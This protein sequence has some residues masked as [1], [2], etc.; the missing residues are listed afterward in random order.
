MSAQFGR[1]PLTSPPAPDF[2]TGPA[3]ARPLLQ[4]PH[5]VRLNGTLICSLAGAQFPSLSSV[6][7]RSPFVMAEYA[8]GDAFLFS[9]A[10]GHLLE[11]FDV[12]NGGPRPVEP[13][14]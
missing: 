3:S 6:R 13:G 8:A 14:K 1:A 11:I 10:W 5:N 4:A 2:G 12:K 9:A 7:R